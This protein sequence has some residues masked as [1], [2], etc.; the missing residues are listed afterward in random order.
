[1]TH[2]KTAVKIADALKPLGSGQ[3]PQEI[4]DLGHQESMAIISDVD[5][6]DYILTLQ[7]VPRQRPRPVLQ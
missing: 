1:M 2:L 4:F 5:G 3:V 6:V 7:K